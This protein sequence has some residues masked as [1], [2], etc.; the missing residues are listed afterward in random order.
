MKL[1]WTKYHDA[2]FWTVYDDKGS[3]ATKV[4]TEEL[5]KLFAAAAEM[6]NAC[7][8][9]LKHLEHSGDCPKH[10]PDPTYDSG[11]HIR[12]GR[13]PCPVCTLE[14]AVAKATGHGGAE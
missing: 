5:A 3:V 9:A 13:S 7:A 11:G 14:R 8:E 10:D 6:L 2:K 12:M 4:K 1:G